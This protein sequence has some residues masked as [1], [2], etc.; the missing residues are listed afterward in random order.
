MPPRPYR[1]PPLVASARRNQRKVNWLYVSGCAALMLCYFLPWFSS[2][3]GSVF[4][5]EISFWTPRYL[6]AMYAGGW[7][8]LASNSVWA[9]AF[10]GVFA[11]FGLGLELSSLRKRKNRWIIRLLTA[12]S[13]AIAFL[14]VF[15]AFAA[16]G[17][18][19]MAEVGRALD[20]GDGSSVAGGILAV[21]FIL[22]ALSSWGLWVMALGM[23]LCAA[24]VYFHPGRARRFPQ[25]LAVHTG[26]KA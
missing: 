6:N 4:G 5:Y 25:P 23:G 7:I 24:S 11:F 3:A 9:F 26:A 1:P 19:Q 20:S 8:V 17:S 18:A 16:A 14:I 10:I 12:V 2:D 13:P 21:V 22:L 15:L